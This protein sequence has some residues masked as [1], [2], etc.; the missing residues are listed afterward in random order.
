MILCYFY[1]NSNPIIGRRFVMIKETDLNKVKDM[2]IT[3]L[4]TEPEPVE[5]IPIFLTHPFFET[6]GVAIRGENGEPVLIDILESKDNFKKVIDF[7]ENMILGFNDVSDIFLL[8]RDNYD[9]TL[10]KYT[11]D[12]LSMR[13]FCKLFGEYWTIAE[14]PNMDVNVPISMSAKWFKEAD[15]KL[16]LTKD[17]YKTYISLPETL[18]IYRGVGVRRSRQGLSWTR[19]YDKANWFAHRFDYDDNEGYI[20][21]AEV[22]KEE[23]L[24]FFSRRDEEEV[25]AYIPEKRI[26]QI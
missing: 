20:L 4:Y 24:A 23:V 19:D 12:Y 13:D 7:Y 25:V 22:K 18:T 26:E 5:S 16:L 2:A 15:K 8:I 14:N 17:E 21:K 9:L 3:I 6:R 10:L 1:K 11:K